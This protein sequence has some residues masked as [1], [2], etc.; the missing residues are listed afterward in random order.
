MNFLLSHP[1]LIIHYVK[2]FKD[3]ILNVEI[4]YAQPFR[5]SVTDFRQPPK[6]P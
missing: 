4:L 3:I 1:P 5:K 2:E 6:N